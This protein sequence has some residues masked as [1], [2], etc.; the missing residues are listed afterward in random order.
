M[1]SILAQQEISVNILDPLHT[2]FPMF[3][4]KFV[5]FVQENMFSSSTM[6]R[7]HVDVEAKE[8]FYRP[9]ILGP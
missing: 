2:F 4:A 8:I 9:I 3:R 1:F 6:C 5:H 7:L